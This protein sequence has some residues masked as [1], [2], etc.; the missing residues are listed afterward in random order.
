MATMCRRPERQ[1]RRTARTATTCWRWKK[2]SQR[3]LPLLDFRAV[4]IHVLP[5]EDH[6]RWHFLEENAT[7]SLRFCKEQNRNR[8]SRRARWSGVTRDRVAYS[9][10]PLLQARIAP[11]PTS[12]SSNTRHFT[13]YFHSASVIYPYLARGVVQHE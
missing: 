8:C 4:S 10:V 7:W 9:P 11:P 2:P 6:A 12:L 3:C 1:L 13:F 5:S